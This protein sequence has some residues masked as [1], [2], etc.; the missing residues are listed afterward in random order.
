MGVP[1]KL[2]PYSAHSRSASA[3]TIRMNSSRLTK[4][5][6]TPFR[7]PGRGCRVVTEV[8]SQTSGYERRICLIT[9]PLPTPDG[10]AS[11]VS[12]CAGGLPESS[13]VAVTGEFADQSR[14]LVDPEPANAA[15]GRDA[16]LLHDPGRPH[17]P[18][19]RQ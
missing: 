16:D 8:D 15:G 11:T 6:S 4:R 13:S 2:P 19:P 7:S 9:L 18:D 3:S 10:P 14:A 5:Y 1:Y 12:R 17:L